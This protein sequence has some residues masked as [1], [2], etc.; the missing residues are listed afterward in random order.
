MGE[1]FLAAHDITV[2]FGG[3]I[4]LDHVS[5]IADAGQ[6]IGVIGP[7]GAGK[8]TLF[9]A[10]LGSIPADGSVRIDGRDVSRWPTYRRAR[11]GLGRTFQSLEVFGSMTV[12][13]NLEFASEAPGLGDRPWNLL[14]RDGHTADAVAVLETLGLAAVADV[15]AA[16]L[17]VGTRR[18]VEFGRALC[19]R[20]TVLLLDEPSSGLDDA[21]TA[22]LGSQIR[23]VASRGIGIVLVEHDMSLVLSTCAHIHVLDFGRE[24]A[25]GS[26]DEIR[27]SPL[28][29]EAYLGT[30]AA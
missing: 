25:A 11:A 17:P 24:I 6:V 26:P 1:P 5:L 19:A 30:G 4:A 13:E 15:R 12:R 22:S 23:S 10:I 27:A 2:R 20:P 18:L 28:V 9:G 21:E 3:L 16:D 14:R 8:S 7:N 29:R